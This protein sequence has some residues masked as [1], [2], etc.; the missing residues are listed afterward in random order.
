MCYPVSPSPSL[1]PSPLPLSPP[2]LPPSSGQSARDRYR[3][4]TAAG[5]GM[6]W[7]LVEKFIKV[8]V[9]NTHAHLYMYMST[10]VH[11]CTYTCTVP[12]CACTYQCCV[13]LLFLPSLLT[14]PLP[15]S[16]TSFLCL[17]LPLLSPLPPPPTSPGP[18]SPA[19]SHLSTHL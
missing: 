12:A 7:Y 18:V 9:F 11:V 6:N 3:D 19:L 15:T 10:C 13:S 16:P 1:L 5:D 4:I 17:S 2:T 8:S 14:L